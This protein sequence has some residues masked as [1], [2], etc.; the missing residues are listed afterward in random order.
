[1][2]IVSL[3]A[4]TILDAGP[5][6]QIEAAAAA[7]FSHVGLRLNP[8][9]TSDAVVVGHAEREREVERA[10]TATGVKLLEVGVFPI[11]AGFDCERWRAVVAFSAK[12]GGRSLVCPIEA[13]EWSQQVEGF[14]AVADLAAEHGMDALV[15]FNP[16]SGCR[17]L[18]G[19]V[20]LVRVAERGNTGLVI[21]AFHLSRS[22]GHPSDLK[23]L[24]KGLVRLVHFCDAAPLPKGER[25][26]DELKAESR[27]ARMLPGEGVLWLDELLEALA[28]DV[29]LSVE[30][31]SQSIRQLSTVDRAKRTYAATMAVLKANQATAGLAM[32]GR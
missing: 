18:S 22:G 16:Y 6:G 30:A 23:S 32:H 12:L 5:V 25:T 9:L 27:T 15:E 8:L 11:R 14:Q 3:A 2:P 26:F 7:G 31:P 10:M 29:P 1:M 13:Q 4:L 20:D 28:D 24:D 17:S 19:A 21:D